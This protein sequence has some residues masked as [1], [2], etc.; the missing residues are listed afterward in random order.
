M[1]FDCLDGGVVEPI[2][3]DKSKLS[4]DRSIILMDEENQTV[5]LWHGKF[6]GLVQ[7]RTSLRQA[8]SLKGHGYKAGNAIIGRDLTTLTEIDAR[9]I[10]RVP[11]DTEANEKLMSV[12]DQ[13]FSDTGNYVYISGGGSGTS[14]KS[15]S[16][17]SSG[18]SSKPSKKVSS[19]KVE[20]PKVESKKPEPKSKSKPKP[21]ASASATSSRPKPSQAKSSTE[22]SAELKKGALILAI[23]D[24]YKDIW[25]SKKSDGKIS[26]EQMDGKI[27]TFDVMNGNIDYKSGSFAEVAA[28]KKSN[29][30]QKY[31]ELVAYL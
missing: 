12:L 2:E 4:D 25:L 6:R 3:L 5:W 18:G 11:E 19:P 9:K 31:N 26:V 24:Q 22:S 8:E 16:S 23:I 28:D 7:R 14:S 15:S 29:I 1:M 10:G 21:S 17:S 27:C 13:K 30:E 20:A